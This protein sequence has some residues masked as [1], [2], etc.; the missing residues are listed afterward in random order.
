M[1]QGSHVDEGVPGGGMCKGFCQDSSLKKFKSLPKL[2]STNE[3]HFFLLLF[4][5][6]NSPSSCSC[7]RMWGMKHSMEAKL[8]S[9]SNT[10]ILWAFRIWQ[11]DGA[12]SNFE[13]IGTMMDLGENLRGPLIQ[14]PASHTLHSF[15]TI[16]A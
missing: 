8:F 15:C 1:E 9:W 11:V 13:T 6:R 7:A 12:T 4:Q 14:S 3:M 16:M 2:A 5:R 10:Y